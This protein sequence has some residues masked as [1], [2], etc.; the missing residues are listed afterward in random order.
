MK[1]FVWTL[2]LVSVVTRDSGCAAQSTGGAGDIGSLLGLDGSGASNANSVNSVLSSLLASGNINAN[3]TQALNDAFAS[4]ANNSS[5]A[6]I[7]DL[8]NALNKLPTGTDTKDLIDALNT[9]PIPENSTSNGSQALNASAAN[10]V[11]ELIGSL[12]NGVGNLSDFSNI[13]NVMNAATQSPD[14]TSNPMADLISSLQQPMTPTNLQNIAD[15]FQNMGSNGFQNPFSQGNSGAGNSANQLLQSMAT[16][17]GIQ[18]SEQ[19]TLEEFFRNVA[20]GRYTLIDLIDPN[21][22]ARPALNLIGKFVK[23]QTQRAIRQAVESTMFMSFFIPH[24]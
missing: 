19:Q 11:E 14:S 15:M 23:D 12:G 5:A 2:I 3:N 24:F 10:S 18:P 13:L 22:P 4:L 6:D 8:M 7:K 16:A 21:S 9:L 17:L 20:T 1:V